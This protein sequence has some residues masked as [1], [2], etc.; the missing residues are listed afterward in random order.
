MLKEWKTFAPLYRDPI[1]DGCADPTIIYNHLEK[2]WWMVYTQRR[3]I[4]PV[5]GV[6]SSHGTSLGIAASVDNGKTW[7]YRGTLNLS[8]D[9]GHNTFWAPEIIYDEKTKIYHMYVT[10]IR[11]IPSKW[12]KTCK[13]GIAHF[14]S[15]NLWDW[16]FEAFV[17]NVGESI[18]DACIHKMPDGKYRMWYR[19]TSKDC[20]T[21]AMDSEDLYTWETPFEVI[22]DEKAEGPNVFFYKGYYW[23]VTDPLGVRHGLAVYRSS[24][25]TNWEKKDYILNDISTRPLDNSPGRHPDIYADSNNAYIFYFTQPYKDYTQ[26]IDFNEIANIDYARCVIQVARLDV[27]DGKLVCDR[28]EDFEIML[29]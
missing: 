11:G 20:A 25:L 13:D 5:I 9:R 1:Y 17:S 7:V 16:G 24:D 3:A 2:E 26:K 8:I 27:I 18:I 6:S 28:N 4:L 21:W 12:G 22:N 23:L 15:E 14:T 29:R 19:D 10:Y